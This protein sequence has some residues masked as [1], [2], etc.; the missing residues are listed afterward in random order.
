MDWNGMD[1]IESNGIEWNRMEWNDIEWIESNG[2]MEL[3][4]GFCMEFGMNESM[5]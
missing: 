3:M 5:D 4:N 1:W 2:C